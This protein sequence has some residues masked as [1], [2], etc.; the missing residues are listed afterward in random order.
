M[1]GRA[2]GFII[3]VLALVLPWRLRVILSEI[4]GWITQFLYFTY[5]GILNYI[6]N[7]IKKSKATDGEKGKFE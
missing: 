1:F 3:C 2:I 5:F 4:L 6:L 7:E